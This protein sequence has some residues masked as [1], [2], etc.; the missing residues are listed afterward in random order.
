MKK[1]ID[2]ISSLQLDSQSIMEDMPRDAALKFHFISAAASMIHGATVVHLY[3]W[4]MVTDPGA[5]PAPPQHCPSSIGPKGQ[6]VL[7]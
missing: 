1:S 7:F 4:F 3:G 2:F 5:M 6:E